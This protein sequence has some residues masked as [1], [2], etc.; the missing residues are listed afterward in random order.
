MIEI[1]LTSEQNEILEHSPTVH[2]RVLAGPG[3][4][5]SF[6][7]VLLLQKWLSEEENL[8][9]KLLTFTRAATS[10]LSLKTSNYTNTEKIHPLTIHSFAL[11]ILL[12][13][14][15][16]SGLPEPIRIA[17]SWEHDKIVIPTLAQLMSVKKNDIKEYIRW[18]SSSW[19]SLKDDEIE[20]SQEVKSRFNGIWNE[21]RTILGYTMLSELPYR[22]HEALEQHEQIAGIDVNIIMVDEYQDLNACDLAVLHKIADR[23]CSLVVS[24]DDDQSIYSMRDAAPE[25]IRRFNDEYSNST[26]YNLSTSIRCGSK[27][28]EWANHVI[29]G[30]SQRPRDKAILTAREENPQGETRLLSFNDHTV[31]ATGVAQIVRYL[32]EQEAIPPSE[33]LILLPHDHNGSLSRL[34]KPE[35]EKLNIKFSDPS[36][37]TETLSALQ[38]REII[39]RLRLLA[40]ANDSLAWASILNLTNGLGDRFY[41]YIYE[42]AVQSNKTFGEILN[43]EAKN[44]FENSPSTIRKRAQNRYNEIITWLENQEQPQG[45]PECGWN[46][47]IQEVLPDFVSDD[48]S[49]ILQSV[50][51]ATI[52]NCSLSTFLNR[53]EPIAKD[54]AQSLSNGVRIMNMV[55]SKGLTVEATILVSA[56]R[57]VIPHPKADPRESRRLLYVAM[58]RA[59]RFMFITWARQRWGQSA[60]VANQSTSKRMFTDFLSGGPV[61]SEKGENYLSNILP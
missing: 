38:S 51:E 18:M 27:I 26:S 25:G 28:V 11:S 23:G 58:T 8:K 34:I 7:F 29:V 17:D 20:I 1:N 59:R 33:I 5:K 50:Q 45:T 36:K 49:K 10:E 16:V 39:A 15:G 46:K 21:N 47:W 37:I 2:G 13:N 12:K 6:T 9:V 54:I 60:R 43:N 32:M 4:G 56:E 40:N 35:L 24:G 53:I 61:R 22:L 30:D 44:D 57:E 52:E 31:E 48:L 41:N 55:A 19:E 3:T 42:K 14:P